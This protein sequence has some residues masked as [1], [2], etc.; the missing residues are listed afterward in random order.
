MNCFIGLFI[1]V[2]GT[3]LGSFY[4]VVGWRL[5]R[6]ESIVSPPSHCPNC[7]HKLKILDLIP[8]LSYVFQK[9]KCRY[10][11][12]KIAWYYPIFE[13]LCGLVFLLC[14]LVIYCYIF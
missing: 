9:G 2:I 7:N 10:C 4:N 5:P 1:F 12:Q 13:F 6:G 11:H 14:Y 8:I 3:V